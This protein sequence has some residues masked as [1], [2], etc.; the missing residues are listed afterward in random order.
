M[1]A[2]AKRAVAQ[3]A[4]KSRPPSPAIES[5][6]SAALMQQGGKTREPPGAKAPAA[7]LGSSRVDWLLNPL[8][9]WHKIVSVVFHGL[10]QSYFM[11]CFNCFQTRFSANQE[12]PISAFLLATLRWR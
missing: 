8:P 11:D 10:F 5:Q 6:F 4:P 7:R 12:D 1:S 9:I 2:Q 3:R